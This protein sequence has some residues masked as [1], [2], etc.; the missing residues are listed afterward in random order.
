MGEYPAV[1]TASQGFKFLRDQVDVGGP[2]FSRTDRSLWKYLDFMHNLAEQILQ[3]EE[4]GKKVIWHSILVPR[5][6]IASFDNV[7]PLC[8]EIFS[9]I[10]GYFTEG[11]TERFMGVS[12]GYGIP[13][14]VCSAHRI[15]DGMVINR[16]IPTPHVLVGSTNPCDSIMQSWEIIQNEMQVPKF[17]FDIPYHYNED[18]LAYVVDENHRLVKFL[19]DHLGQKLNKDLLAKNLKISQRV[20]RLLQEVNELRSHVPSPMHAADNLNNVSMSLN[21][22]TSEVAIDYF[23]TLKSEMEARSQQGKGVVDKERYRLAWLGGVPLFAGEL[24]YWMEREYNAVLALE[25]NTFW[26]KDER[27]DISKPMDYIARKMFAR[28]IRAMNCGPLEQTLP[29]MTEKVKEYRCDG[30]V[31]FASIGCPQTCG[32]IRLRRDALQEEVGVPL[33]ILSGDVCDPT[34][35]SIDELKNKLEEF[36]EILEESSVPART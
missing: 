28:C 17:Q 31:F 34:V 9:L 36:F 27:M 20:D 19:E 23:E 4:T 30:V 1:R 3:A 24:L 22:C 15:M 5:E 33:T 12:A 10:G 2:P 8:L 7:V 25:Q 32:G 6:I 35:V 21:G 29:L 14:E 26:L 16:E 13:Q 18:S 11:S